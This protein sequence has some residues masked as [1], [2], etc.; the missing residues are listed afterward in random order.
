[1]IELNDLRKQIIAINAAFL[2]MEEA[3]HNHDKREFRRNCEALREFATYA[4]NMASMI[5][6]NND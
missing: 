2:D 1:M 6:N 4:A 5:L 3:K